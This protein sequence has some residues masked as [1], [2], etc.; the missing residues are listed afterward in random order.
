MNTEIWLVR[1]GETEW[2]KL[3]KFQGSTDI[4]LSEEGRNQAKALKNLISVDFDAVYASPLV[5]AVE[6]AEI[7]CR[8]TGL[9]VLP[10]E[11]IRE[12]NFGI[13]EGLTLEEIEHKYPEEM[14]KWRSDEAEGAFVGGDL[15]ILNASN[16]AAATIREIAG[17]HSGK[18]VLI[19]AHGGIIK[20]ALI[21]LF[22]WKMTMYH[23][24]YVD[25]TAIT[26]I[27]F[28]DGGYPVLKSFNETGHLG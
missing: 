11:G 13:F 21:G 22:E 14:S 18:R 4:E 17:K 5:R 19:V 6:T 20:A 26:K 24:F 7:L 3:G 9:T 1:H 27:I 10:C 2:N 15:S 16:R 25:N 12:I 28:R 23:H 8:D